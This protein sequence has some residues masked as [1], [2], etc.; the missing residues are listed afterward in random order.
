MQ[1]VADNAEVS[2]Q[3]K[4]MSKLTDTRKA[5]MILVKAYNNQ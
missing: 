3:L 2:K 4:N 1:M 5:I